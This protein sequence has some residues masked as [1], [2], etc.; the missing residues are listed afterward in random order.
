[1]TSLDLIT[2]QWTGRGRDQNLNHGDICKVAQLRPTVLCQT[3]QH[4]T[5]GLP[6]GATRCHSQGFSKALST[7]LTHDGSYYCNSIGRWWFS[8]TLFLLRAWASGRWAV[9]LCY[10]GGLM[11]WSGSSTHTHTNTLHLAFT[12]AFTF[13]H[14]HTHIHTHIHI[15]TR[16]GLS[17]WGSFQ[18]LSTHT[19][20]LTHAHTH[21]GPSLHNSQGTDNIIPCLSSLWLLSQVPHTLR[22][23]S[24][25]CHYHHLWDSLTRFTITWVMFIRPCNGKLKWDCLIGQVKAVA[26]SFRLF[27][28]SLVTNEC[29]PV[30]LSFPRT[31]DLLRD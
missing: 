30:L 11:S 14:T 7:T 16:R 19:H 31:I 28:F 27:F 22:Q 5:R 9:S 21:T 13:T 2:R 17:S 26:P 12:H 29:T 25:V 4:G 23:P 8:F 10:R 15:Y 20:T 3:L 24:L 1:M 6:H 18:G